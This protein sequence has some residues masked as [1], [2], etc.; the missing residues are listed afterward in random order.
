VL[1]LATS[2]TGSTIAGGSSP[3]SIRMDSPASP[4]SITIVG[5][6]GQLVGQSV[7]RLLDV[8]PKCILCPS[9]VA[10]LEGVEQDLMLAGDVDRVLVIALGVIP[11]DVVDKG[12]DPK[13]S[14][15]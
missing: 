15:Q 8:R 9:W 1:S 5:L 7:T 3:V 4:P 2:S 6:S 13:L 11:T 12:R 10:G 14:V